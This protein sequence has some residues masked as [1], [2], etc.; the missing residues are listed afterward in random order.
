MKS[1]QKKKILKFSPKNL[2]NPGNGINFALAKQRGVE[3]W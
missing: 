1:P 2:E 3:Q